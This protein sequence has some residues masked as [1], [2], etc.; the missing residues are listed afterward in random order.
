MIGI[1]KTFYMCG[2]VDLIVLSLF[3]MY[4]LRLSIINRPI[5]TESSVVKKKKMMGIFKI[6]DVKAE[7]ADIILKEKEKEKANKIAKEK[8]KTLMLE[9][10][11]AKDKLKKAAD[12]AAAAAA[13]AAVQAKTA[14]S[15]KLFIVKK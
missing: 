14:A 6:K 3:A 13:S 2:A 12:S 1:S 8:A 4:Q 10:K 11:K 15:N 7:K 9:A 5:K